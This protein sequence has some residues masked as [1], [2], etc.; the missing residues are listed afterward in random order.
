[1]QMQIKKR[2]RKMK[3]GAVT[4]E[5]AILCIMVAA[6]VIIAVIVFGHAV[7]R[8]LDTAKGA[9]AG[10][11]CESGKA[12]KEYSAQAMRKEKRPSVLKQL[13]TIAAK[14]AELPGKV[15]NR[16]KKRELDR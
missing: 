7:W 2:D 11:G 8:G 9:T 16:D 13:R 3:R 5:T 12:F 10:Y 4:M 15:V 14:I 6:A 1:M